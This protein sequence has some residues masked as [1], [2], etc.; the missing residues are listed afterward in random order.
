MQQLLS[1]CI[2]EC[3]KWGLFAWKLTLIICLLRNI[4]KRPL[5]LYK[6]LVEKMMSLIVITFLPASHTTGSSQPKAVMWE[7]GLFTEEV[8]HGDSLT[9]Q[10][11][12]S[13]YCY[14]DKVDETC[15]S[16]FNFPHHLANRGVSSMGSASV[17][18]WSLKKVLNS[19]CGIL[20]SA[21]LVW[22]LCHKKRNV[23]K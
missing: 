18:S 13:P 1:L 10:R 9:A 7:K 3:F 15:I 2:C 4:T 21:A 5:S 20:Q 19:H 16:G 23:T 12:V 6:D 11:A 14:A 17:M 8:C 22:K